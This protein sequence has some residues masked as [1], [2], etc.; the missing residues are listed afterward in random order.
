[1]DAASLS[2]LADDWH[3]ISVSRRHRVIVSARI[4]QFPA[5]WARL[6]PETRANK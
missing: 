4:K 1:L 6:W 5:T 2:L 3:R